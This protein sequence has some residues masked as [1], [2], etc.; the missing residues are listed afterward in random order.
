MNFSFLNR[1]IH[2]N[3]EMP[4]LIGRQSRLSY[5]EL[6]EKVRNT[7]S[8][9][10]RNGITKQ[11]RVILPGTHDIDFVLLLLALWRIGAIPIPLNIRLK[12]NERK[13][14][15]S[16]ASPV[17]TIPD[18]HTF[19]EIKYWDKG[20]AEQKNVE[21]DSGIILF[22]SGTT[23]IPK[24]VVLSIT[25]LLSSADAV[26]N[27]L[28]PSPEDKWLASLPFYHI[29]G[30]MILVRA[31]AAG[32][33]VILPD[34]FEVSSTAYYLK[35]FRPA[36]MSF[37]PTVL[38]R[39][40]ENNVYPNSEVKF[41]LLGG[42]PVKDELAIEAVSK[43][44]EILKVYGSSETCSM[45]TA[46]HINDEINKLSSAGRPLNGNSIKIVSETKQELPNGEIGEIAVTGPTIFKEYLNNEAETQLR[47]KNSF[48]L[49]GDI[50][51]LDHDGYLYI[52]SRRTDLIISG[53]ENIS[54][55]EIENALLNIPEVQQACVI[56]ITDEEWGQIPAAVVISEGYI[57]SESIIK[58]LRNSLASYKI[59][60][61][62]IFIDKFPLT[63]L[64]KINKEKLKALF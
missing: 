58:A 59:P 52:H 5:L 9:L 35:E 26:N 38:K 31:F 27:I 7:I 64:G 14:I 20:A 3:Q 62:I 23:G 45:F 29:G 50:G 33:T 53:G 57:D 61:K 42:G 2:V 1:I 16:L 17:F 48:Y 44:W 6:D 46:L 36:F 55:V 11:S 54:P 43:G 30:I 22:T 12:E 21:W 19:D 49:T 37:V 15:I 41:M 34:S 39:L 32:L 25:N 28:L 8:V 63:P 40:L 47:I 56:G 51:H 24:G 4:A 60:K 18:T 10:E 13:D